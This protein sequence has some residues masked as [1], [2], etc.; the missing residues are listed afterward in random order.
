MIEDEDMKRCNENFEN[1]T[2]KK[3]KKEDEEKG[4]VKVTRVK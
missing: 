1:L 4:E 3:K 2:R